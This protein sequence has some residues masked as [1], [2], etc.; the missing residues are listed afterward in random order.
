MSQRGFKLAT[1]IFIHAQRLKKGQ[2][3]Y[4]FGVKVQG[5]NDIH[6]H[7]AMPSLTFPDF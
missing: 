6:V 3:P 5:H 4:I 1:P 7:P 2:C